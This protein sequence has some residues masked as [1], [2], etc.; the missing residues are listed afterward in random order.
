MALSPVKPGEIAAVVT[1]L[2]MTRRPAPR[3]AAPS[4]LRL[5]RWK[6]PA[7]EKYRTLFRRVGEPWLW[8]SRL[9]M[10]EDKL[11]AI[12]HDPR[13]EIY[14]V[15]DPKGIEVGMIELDF[16]VAGECELTYFGLIRELTGKGFG[17][18][19]I[20]QATMLAWRAGVNRFWVHTCTLD[21]PAAL[22]FYIRAGFTPFRREIET[23]P[24]PRLTGHLPREC[25]PHI[26]LIA[27]A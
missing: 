18:W 2:E 14:A 17:Q 13:V 19:M 24:D 7:T 25:A 8:F 6:D 15:V 1:S 10:A 5:V 4:P 3:P 23:F 20:A 16:S 9:V 22:Q 27:A 12:I 11:T 21:H 26:P